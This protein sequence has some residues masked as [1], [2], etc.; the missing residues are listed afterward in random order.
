MS[1]EASFQRAVEACLERECELP[2]GAALVVAVSGGPDS[3]A[4]LSA[5]ARARERRSD[6]LLAVSC[7]H[8]L[9]PEAR[10]EIH[11]VEQAARNWGVEFLALELG[12]SPGANLQERAREAR[13]RALWTA[14]DQ[15]FGESAFLVTAHHADDRAETV[16]LRLLRGTSLAGLGVLRAR[17]GRLLRPA[18]RC[19]RA[20]VLTHL[21]RH[22]IASVHDPSNEDPRYQRVRVRQELMPLLHELAPGIVAQLCQLADEAAQG[23]PALGLNREQRN[24]LQRALRGAPGPVDVWLPRGLR[25][26]RGAA[27]GAASSAGSSAGGVAADPGEP[28]TRDD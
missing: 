2:Q 6:Q 1:R 10:E 12:L 8:G 27:G 17:E 20:Q 25:L 3:M 13:Y 28:G 4:L 9:R 23:E 7:D 5:L 18:I 22:A 15:R 21:E 19:T 24:Q 16:L 26:I 11:L 14:A